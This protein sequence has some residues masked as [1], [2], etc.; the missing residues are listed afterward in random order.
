MRGIQ[1]TL[2]TFGSLLLTGTAS[3]Q[4]YLVLELDGVA[5]A[6]FVGGN[7][8]AAA[9]DVDGDGVPDVIIGAPSAF[10]GF[11]RARIHSGA[12]GALLRAFASNVQNDLFGY[13]VSGTGDLDGDGQGDV[14]VGILQSSAGGVT[15]AGRAT[16]YSG[17]TGV[18]LWSRDGTLPFDFLG[19]AVARVG[20]LDG[21]GIEDPAVGV[22][23]GDNGAAFDAGRVEVLSGATGAPVLLVIGSGMAEYLGASVAG[24]GDVSGD[25]IPDLLAGAR[26]ADPNGATNAGVVRCLSGADGSILFQFPGA[27]PADE[28]GTSVAGVGDVS[29]DGVPD[30]FAGASEPS[31]GNGYASLFSGATGA[32]LFTVGGTG[33]S[34][35][36]GASVSGAGDLSG[37][38]VPDLLVGAPGAVGAF[39]TVAAGRVQVLSGA[40]G[41]PLFSVLGTNYAGVLGTSVASLGDVNGDGL[42]DF[43]AGEPGPFATGGI[44]RVHSGANGAALFT[45]LGQNV[46][47][48][49][50]WAAAGV[51]DVDGDGLEDILV[52]APNADVALVPDAGRA[53]L[54]SGASGT[55]LL[56]IDGSVASAVLGTAV[57]GL[58]D[59]DGDGVPDI[60][61]G[62]PGESLSSGQVRVYSSGTGT[63]FLVLLGTM[64]GDR[65]GSAIA[66]VGD[67]TGDGVPDL[68]VGAPQPQGLSAGYARAFSGSTGAVLATYSGTGAA[69]RMGTA[70]AGL[71]DV[72]GDGVPDVAVGAPEVG[73]PPFVSQGEGHVRVLSGAGGAPLYQIEGVLIGAQFGTAVAA[74]GDVDGDGLADL[75]VGA[76][77]VFS[78]ASGAP[79]VVFVGQTPGERLGSS[80]GGGRDLDGDGVPDFVLGSPGI[81]S[82]GTVSP[83]FARIFSGA[84]GAPLLSVG[85]TASGEGIALS[86][87]PVGDATGDG[88]PDLLFASPFADPGGLGDAGR[89]RILSLIGLPAAATPFGTGCSGTGGAVP[90]IATYGGSPAPGNV[91]FG[92]SIARGRGGATALLFL[93]SLPDPVGLP[94]LGCTLHLA[95]VITAV[96]LPVGLGGPPGA[97][98]EGFRLLALSV[99]P[100]PGLS[101]GQIHLQWAVLDPGSGNGTFSA[102]SALTI[103][104]P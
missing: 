3:G 88:V 21:D 100:V 47:D 51:G 73:A 77:G 80:V 56:S 69:A 44:A 92:I 49:F 83:G 14:I 38:T 94:V 11:G 54:H 28:F 71:G 24:P 63:S 7:S 103:T 59:V 67:L 72:N 32:L 98:G 19:S 68:V 20:D 8:V 62:S 26:G 76:A 102:T 58:G 6:T 13:S 33:F 99:P 5:G 34:E 35:K 9:G 25:G 50:G 37:D 42:P 29:G 95:G 96:P 85:G 81:G 12:T 61:V 104:V 97:A 41:A 75:V 40:G 17:A 82:P 86:V 52:G 84:S 79:L 66:G 93:G 90:T 10:D 22:L 27:G 48:Q 89:V 45:F 101:G 57:A 36:F 2:L 70:I 78:G 55:V 43:A 53:T 18:P 65:F 31:G 16:A 30:L 91:D 60:A 39:S 23:Y 74:A 15:A 87:A 1:G 46:G 4:G 64:P